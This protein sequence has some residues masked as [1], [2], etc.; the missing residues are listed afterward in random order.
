MSEPVI[1]IKGIMSRIPH[2]YPFLL[3]DKIVEVTPDGVVG[4]KNV[5]ANEPHF[6]GHWPD[7][8]VMPGVLQLEA[9][10]QAG[11][12][13]LFGKLAEEN[14][15]TTLDVFFRRI[16][17]ATFRKVVRPGDQLLLHVKVIKQRR[18]LYVMSGQA[19][20]DGQVASEAE[21]TAV[22]RPR[23]DADGAE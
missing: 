8:P 6:Q 22:V 3:V 1:D 7:E 5:T 16:D 10:A 21:M 23:G 14:P 12:V 13:L 15:D 11:A 17:K 9:L 4:L 19:M 18:E 20:V 2:R